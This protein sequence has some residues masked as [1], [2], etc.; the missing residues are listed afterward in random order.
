M[1][2]HL[3]RFLP[4]LAGA[5]VL[6]VGGAASAGGKTYGGGGHQCC[7][8]TPPPP[9]PSKPCCKPQPPAPPPPAKPP[10]FNNTNIN[11]NINN[12][13]NNVNVN[14]HST[15]IAVATANANATA[16][17][18]SQGGGGS[19]GDTFFFS[20][21]G[22]QVIATP[23]FPVLQPLG[24]MGEAMVKKAFTEKR[25]VFKQVIVQAVCI[26]DRGSPH[27]ASQIFPE[28]D[29]MD[30]YR[31]EIFRCV[32]GS[33]LQ[34]T[35][36]EFQGKIAFD[37]GETM[38]CMKGEALF[39][40]GGALT[41][42][43]ATPQRNCYERSLLRRH[44]AGVKVFKMSRIEEFTSFREEIVQSTQIGTVALDGGVGGFVH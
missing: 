22:A 23:G 41:C 43:P 42:R 25:S 35:I 36:A 1:S 13:F 40:E 15:N 32:A 14:V 24:V 7:K 9:P 20:G 6:A 5:L 8:P 21:G 33:K 34:A 38:A 11:K 28:R 4:L 44:G 16:N 27:A 12:N 37:G 30:H 39:Y 29:V 31:G 26:D 3:K 17:S 2:A 18:N 19:S 10:V